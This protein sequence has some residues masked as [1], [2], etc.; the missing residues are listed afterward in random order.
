MPAIIRLYCYIVYFNNHDHIG[1]AT[2]R[3]RPLVKDRDTLIEQLVA[4][5]NKR[6][7]QN[8]SQTSSL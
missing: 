8:N 6:G 2:L 4:N 1:V 5:L 7:T 3:G